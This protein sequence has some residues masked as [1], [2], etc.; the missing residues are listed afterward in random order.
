MR[1]PRVRAPRRPPTSALNRAEAVRRSFGLSQTKRRRDPRRE[2]AS[3]GKPTGGCPPE[4]GAEFEPSGG[5][6]H[7]PCELRLAASFCSFALPPG[8]V[9]R[10]SW[11][12]RE[13]SE[14]RHPLAWIQHPS[15][16]QFAAA[17]YGSSGTNASAFVRADIPTT[18]HAAATSISCSLRIAGRGRPEI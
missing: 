18:S 10:R 1:R 8:M 17:D 6:P 14:G 7:A 5:W 15:L 16:A 13:P 3:A 9:V 2:R 11:S 12:E 4:L